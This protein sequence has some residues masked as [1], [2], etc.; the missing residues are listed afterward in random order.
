[1]TTTAPRARTHT[2]ADRPR[3]VELVRGPT[4][5][6]A[7]E[8]WRSRTVLLVS[9]LLPLLWLFVIG[10]IAGNEIYDESTGLRVMQFAA[11]TAIV[12]GAILASLPTVAISI[13]DARQSGVLKRLRGTPLPSWAY[14]LGRGLAAAA[15]AIVAVALAWAVAVLAYD[16]QIIWRTLFAS[17]VTLVLAIACYIAI[18]LAIS[19]LA[20]STVVAQA[21]SIGGVLILAFISELFTIGGSF[22]LVITRTAD[23]LPVKPVS[24]ALQDQFNPY[25]T[26]SGWDGR[27]IAVLLI[28][29]VLAALVA[30]WG[31][32]DRERVFR[33][34]RA[35]GTVEGEAGHETPAM[36]A[37]AS[38]TTTAMPVATVAGRPSDGA[39]LGGQVRAA[40]TSLWRDPVGLFFAIVMPLGL[41]AL[42]AGPNRD[43]STPDGI[44]LPTLLMA[45][46][47][48]WGVAYTM[49]STVPE[50]VVRARERGVLKRLR[51]TPLR[52][53][54]Y[55][56]GRVIAGVV[57]SLVVAVLVVGFGAVA[58]GVDV[59][60]VKV[61]LT[62]GLVILGAVVI[63]ACGFLLAARVS[64]TKAFTALSLA[65]L[66][67]VAFFSDVFVAEAPD[68]MDRVGAIFPLLHLQH[69]LSDVLT[70]T[71]DVGTWWHVAVLVVWGVVASALA[72]R[73]FRWGSRG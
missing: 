16:V 40:L 67:P 62:A 3:A 58:Y 7:L 55:L 27:A 65:I 36:H 20:R 15:L 11:P 39:L 53:A 69:S 48:A 21:V 10:A 13:T 35:K 57:L 70:G 44:P 31:W 25:L 56:T 5:H 49:F 43:W 2:H 51:G 32:P 22:P 66:L 42:M 45:S 54:T 33:S 8:S 61:V 26:G 12:M 34:R 1:M 38:S 18:G 50:L 29:L 30:V 64:S 41:Y 60:V 37:G 9:L 71:G 19:T 52:P 17:I 14:L 68:W 4:A 59:T 46:M 6:A 63:A 24:S 23:L 47:T 72:V 28:W 73:L